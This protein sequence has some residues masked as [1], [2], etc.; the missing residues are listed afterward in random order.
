M[1]SAGVSVDFGVDAAFIPD[2]TA[3][4]IHSAYPRILIGDA[5]RKEQAIRLAPP[6]RR[7]AH[8]RSERKGRCCH[9][10]TRVYS[11]ARIRTQGARGSSAVEEHA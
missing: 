2:A 3:A 11:P 8:R 9:A 5:E 7:V 1:P 6:E 4:A 10:N